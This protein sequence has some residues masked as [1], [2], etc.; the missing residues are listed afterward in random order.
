MIKIG[1]IGYGS[2]GSMLVRGFIASGRI[3]PSEIIVTKVFRD[4]LPDVFDEMFS[5]T[6]R[7]RKALYELANKDYE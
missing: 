2:M 6:L 1:F 7:K 5:K 4:K 3:N